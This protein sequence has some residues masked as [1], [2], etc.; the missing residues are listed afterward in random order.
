M[1]HCDGRSN[2]AAVTASWFGLL[3]VSCFYMCVCALLAIY[4]TMVK[5][6]SFRWFCLV[7]FKREREAEGQLWSSGIDNEWEGDGYEKAGESEKW[8][9]LF[10]VISSQMNTATAPTHAALC[11][12][13]TVPDLDVNTASA[14]W[15]TRTRCQLCVCPVTPKY[16]AFA[17]QLHYC[18]LGCCLTQE[19]WI[20]D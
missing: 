11:L 14:R 3:R 10:L 18:T 8:K 20:S 15:D 4:V 17:I 1:A 13:T 7:C 19:I 6:R 16:K 12:I 5:P 9:K 2:C